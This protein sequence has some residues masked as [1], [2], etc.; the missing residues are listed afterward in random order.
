M[1][2]SAQ[3]AGARVTRRRCGKTSSTIC[4]ALGVLSGGIAYLEHP[5]PVA[6]KDGP[7]EGYSIFTDRTLH[8]HGGRGASAL[9]LLQLR[10]PAGPVSSGRPAPQPAGG[11]ASHSPG[12]AGEHAEAPKGGP[13]RRASIAAALPAAAG[14]S[15]L[16][17]GV[18]AALCG[19]QR[20]MREPAPAATKS[21]SA[22]PTGAVGAKQLYL[23]TAP[24]FLLQVFL[25]M[26]I[27]FSAALVASR[28]PALRNACPYHTAVELLMAKQ[29]GLV[30]AVW[31]VF[32]L[33]SSSCCAIQLFLNVFNVG[34]AGFNTVL[35]PWRPVFIGLTAT[36]QITVW[37]HVYLN[38]HMWP[39]AAVGTF[40]AVSL[41]FLPEILHLLAR[42]HAP[43]TFQE[44]PDVVPRPGAPPLTL[45]VEGMGCAACT[46]AVH[47]ICAEMSRK[48]ERVGGCAVLF[49]EQ[50]VR[51]AW[52]GGKDSTDSRSAVADDL[53]RR[54]SD[55]GFSAR[56]AL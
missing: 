41:S 12:G 1:Y 42:L 56:P 23:V 18:V 44:A 38:P 33:F 43:A 35:G 16:A 6:S 37:A 10:N 40:V 21:D 25:S 29:K 31:S 32:G 15:G 11:G 53:C 8:G 3:P 28:L 24:G 26:S 7:G 20:A 34:C 36:L 22:A 47:A 39:M 14:Y 54:L 55:A 45:H 4:V 5:T 30:V 13:H 52:V 19:M 50:L 9:S 46:N 17:A 49:E 48:D 51:C 27:F 2:D